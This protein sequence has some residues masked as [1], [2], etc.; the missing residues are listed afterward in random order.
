MLAGVGCV[1]REEG[2]EIRSAATNFIR[3][4]FT[5]NPGLNISSSRVGQPYDGFMVG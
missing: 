3:Q 1:Q 5:H 2:Q 4:P